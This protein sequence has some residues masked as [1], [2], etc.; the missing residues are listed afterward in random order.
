MEKEALGWTEFKDK[1]NRRFGALG[2]EDGVEKFNKLQ[3]T[4]TVMAQHERFE[5]LRA[6]VLLKNPGQR[7]HYL[8]SNFY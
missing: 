1:V 2:D 8:F 5:D 7:E 6:V 4:S 3:Q